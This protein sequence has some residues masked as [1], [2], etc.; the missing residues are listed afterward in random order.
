[1][2][3]MNAG[4]HS[5]PTG[6]PGQRYHDGQRWTDHFTPNPPTPH[7]APTSVAVAVSAGGGPNNALHAVLTLLSCGLWLPVWI[8]I[9]IFSAGSSSASAAAAVGPG[10]VIATA[11]GRKYVGLMVFGVLMAVGIVSEH[12]WLLAVAL[13]LGGIGGAFVWTLKSAE[14]REREQ[15]REQFERD[16]TS[17][18]ADSENKL[19]NEG[20]PRGTYGQYVP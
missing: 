3:S 14:Q 15:R 7:T 16:M 1:M 19:Y 4:W 13:I 20:D 9:A 11:G 18:R 12:P 6:Q 10:G 8:L 17:R 5:D 2:T